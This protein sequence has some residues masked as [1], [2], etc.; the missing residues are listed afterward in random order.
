MYVEEIKK[1]INNLSKEDIGEISNSSEGRFKGIRELANSIM[2]KSMSKAEI[3]K[4]AESIEL[5]AD[6]KW[7]KAMNKAI[8]NINDGKYITEEGFLKNTKK[9]GGK[10]RCQ[11]D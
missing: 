10:K 8:K 1:E 11:K 3:R 9:D 2:D 4:C 5:L 7:V 6:T